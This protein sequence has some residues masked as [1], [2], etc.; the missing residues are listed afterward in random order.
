MHLKTLKYAPQ[1]AQKIQKYAKF[2][3]LLE[4][5]YNFT[6]CWAHRHSPDWLNNKLL[7]KLLNYLNIFV[8]MYLLLNY[9]P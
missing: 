8:K 1:I 5:I 4:K 2:L 7:T 3:N 6:N 9:L